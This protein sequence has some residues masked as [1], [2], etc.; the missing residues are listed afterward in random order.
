MGRK[1]RPLPKYLAEKLCRIR[2]TLGFSQNEIVAKM[3]LDDLLDRSR[4]SEFE[5]GAEP[6]LI[7]LLRYSELA[8]VTVNVLIDDNLD[9]PAAL[10]SSQRSEGIP[11]QGAKK[12]GRKR[13]SS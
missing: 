3:G 8:N 9:L 6:P 7:V 12:A 1:A 11:R 2:A 13:S 10:P 5:A 4:V